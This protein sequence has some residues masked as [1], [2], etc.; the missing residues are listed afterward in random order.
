[1]VRKSYP[2]KKTG[3]KKTKKTE[4]DTEIKAEAAVVGPNIA[5][6]D[7]TEEIPAPPVVIPQKDPEQKIQYANGHDQKP[8]A[9]KPNNPVI[10]AQPNKNELRF[11]ISE[12][13]M[14]KLKAQAVEEGISL[15]DY[16]R[17]LLAE[18]ATLR[19]WEIVERRM[20]MRGGSGNQY[21][22]QNN[23][24]NHGNGNQNRR[25]GGDRNQ[26]RRGMSQSR[27]QNIMDDKA[28]FLEYV[29]STERQQR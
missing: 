2:E 6:E 18:G 19:A 27:Y 16:L 25:G 24:R 13:L 5:A 21:Q 10:H 14:I 1:M 22:G 8:I 17:E 11:I 4:V 29:R 12:A 9:S 15:Q 3:I 7:K 26:N 28:S 20:Q 23:N